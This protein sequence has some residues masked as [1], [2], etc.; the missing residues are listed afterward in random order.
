M[1]HDEIC[2]LLARLEQEYD[3]NE[4]ELAGLKIWPLVRQS[5]WTELVRNE[6][7]GASG[8]GRRY[9]PLKKLMRAAQLL[10]TRR[11][12]IADLTSSA[13]ISRP[14]A[15]QSL[16][17]CGQKFDRIVDPLI[18]LAQ[19]HGD[20]EKFYL[21]PDPASSTLVFDAKYMYP[22]SLAGHPINDPA[23]AFVS[24]VFERAG[25]SS[26]KGMEAFST[27]WESFYRWY[28]YG[29][30]VFSNSNRLTCVYVVAW[31]FPD[32]MGLVAAARRQGLTT[33]D[34]QH[35]KQGRFH[36]MYGWW[37]K[38]PAEGY[39]M[40]P[41]YFWCWGAPSRDH[42][43][44]HSPERSH[45]LPFVGGYPWIGYYKDFL[46]LPEAQE[47]GRSS[48]SRR[49]LFTLQPPAAG[50]TEPV[51]D[52]II[53]F[54]NSHRATDWRLIVRCHPNFQDG[55][56][57]CSERL[58]SVPSDR[59]ELQDGTSNLYDELL[60]VSHHITAFSSC[61][62]EAQALGI[63]TLL[64]G[65][66]ARTMYAEEIASGEFSWTKGDTGFLADWLQQPSDGLAVRDQVY[67]NGELSLA[68]RQLESFR[69]ARRPSNGID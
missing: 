46:F 54:L 5:L 48:S 1:R 57:Y 62:Y 11:H 64:F 21:N 39:L 42:I 15:L 31:Y 13:F 66:E 51:P 6:A 44:A 63:P 69:L 68:A 24:S 35:G 17:K 50:H 26:K 37:T 47:K 4:Y 7:A 52:F 23:S 18:F 59:Y 58:R 19:K 12:R 32:M 16:D 28:R 36:G 3:V 33:I 10:Q 8:H 14:T 49:I 41:D 22:L 9:Q 60:S 30:A 67:I 29:Q 55:L 43:M 2:S 27:A 61:C 20:V 53:D 25:V 65:E 45:H 34:V 38:L 40:K 56:R